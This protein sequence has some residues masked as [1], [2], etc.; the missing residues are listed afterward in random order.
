MKCDFMIA[1]HLVQ[2]GFTKMQAWALVG[3]APH[4]GVRLGDLAWAASLGFRWQ[5]IRAVRGAEDYCTA[6]LC[7]A[8]P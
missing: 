2:Y 3:A 1:E 5:T 6:R 8:A 7:I 4:Q